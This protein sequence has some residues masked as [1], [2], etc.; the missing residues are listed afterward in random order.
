MRVLVVE[1]ARTR[2]MA[3]ARRTA[4]AEENA[5]GKARVMRRWVRAAG[6]DAGADVRVRVRVRSSDWGMDEGDGEAAEDDE[7]R[8]EEAD[9]TTT[10]TR[11]S[12]YGMPCVDAGENVDEDQA[13]RMLTLM[14]MCLCA[15]MLMLMLMRM[16]MLGTRTRARNASSCCDLDWQ[17][18]GSRRDER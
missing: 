5:G 8:K 1:M 10:E 6:D 4:R 13:R 7:G 16:Q 2:A 15:W 18:Q 3:A 12:V 17:R 11:P 14:Q 9:R